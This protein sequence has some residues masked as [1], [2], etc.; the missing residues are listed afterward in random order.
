MKFL[1][2]C[3]LILLAYAAATFAAG[4]VIGFGALFANAGWAALGA[5]VSPSVLV[6]VFATATFFWL[7]LILWLAA[8]PFLI[9]IILAE[10][11]N[12]R[13]ALAYLLFG[14]ALGLLATFGDAGYMPWL[15]LGSGTILNVITGAVAGLV[16]WLIAGRSAGNWKGI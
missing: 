1:V 4:L 15:K 3:F 13:S 11:F 16:Y 7:F 8:I 10:I 14:T 5:V 2:H 9:A 12:I 6:D